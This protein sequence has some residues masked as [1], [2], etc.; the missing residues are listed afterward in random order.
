MNLASVKTDASKQSRVCRHK[1]LV[2]ALV[3][4]GVAQWRGKGQSRRTYYA[5]DEPLGTLEM[6]LSDS[7]V[8]YFIENKIKQTVKVRFV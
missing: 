2:N 7:L 3:S 8:T 1:L 5:T 4:R 6:F